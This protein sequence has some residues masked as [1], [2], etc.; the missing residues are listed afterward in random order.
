MNT[1]SFEDYVKCGNFLPI[2]QNFILFLNTL[3]NDDKK[4]VG[5]LR[6]SLKMTTI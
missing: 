1:F 4:S 6:K 3:Y 5:Y 2:N